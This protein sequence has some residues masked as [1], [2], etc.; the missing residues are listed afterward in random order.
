MKEIICKPPWY[1]VK[2]TTKFLPRSPFSDEVTCFSSTPCRMWRQFLVFS[3]ELEDFVLQLFCFLLFHHL[4]SVEGE[5]EVGLN[6]PPGSILKY[7]LSAFE[8]Q[9]WLGLCWGAGPGISLDSTGGDSY[10]ELS[11]FISFGSDFRDSEKGE[12]LFPFR[13]LPV[14]TW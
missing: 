10:S 8:C 13:I 6:T 1:L 4:F 2:N 7:P 5:A 14:V 11:F 3:A 12:S 9:H